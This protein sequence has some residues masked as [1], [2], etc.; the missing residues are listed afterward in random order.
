MGEGSPN[1]SFDTIP[2]DVFSSILENVDLATLLRSANL[3]SKYWN[4]F[5]GSDGIFWI[6]YCGRELSKEEFHAAEK[7]SC[8]WKM[9]SSPRGRSVFLLSELLQNTGS[10][11]GK[12]LYRSLF[13]EPDDLDFRTIAREWIRGE[14]GDK[15]EPERTDPG[16]LDALL[17]PFYPLR[18]KRY[19]RKDTSWATHKEP[20]V[21][22]LRMAVN[23][24]ECESYSGILLDGERN[25]PR[26]LP[27][28]SV[29]IEF[30]YDVRYIRNEKRMDRIITRLVDLVRKYCGLNAVLSEEMEQ[31]YVGDA[32]ANNTRSLTRFRENLDEIQKRKRGSDATG[33]ST[34]G[35]RKKVNRSEIEPDATNLK[36][37]GHLISGLGMTR[38]NVQGGLSYPVN[39]SILD[40][41]NMTCLVTCVFPPDLR[42]GFASIL[43][44]GES[45]IERIWVSQMGALSFSFSS[46][47]S[48]SQEQLDENLRI[49]KEEIRSTG[50]DM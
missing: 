33:E 10:G 18:W 46:G 23:I 1:V 48:I 7:S 38:I 45:P 42:N 29:A 24:L 4:G 43:L 8:N 11:L 36:V 12:V 47:T 39:L 37:G 19:R 22:L 5:A 3:V 49:L 41:W 9:L 2:Q 20:W 50:S 16:E 13:S 34:Q 44:D 31:Y 17:V 6:R 26:I 14:D 21:N 40:A 35:G 28:S 27:Q 32:P 30:G 25:E 15:R